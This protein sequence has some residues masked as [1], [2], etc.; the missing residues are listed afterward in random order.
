MV[1]EGEVY[2]HVDSKYV[3]ILVVKEVLPKTVNGR[4]SI[5][6]NTHKK[7]RLERIK[8]TKHWYNDS[9]EILTLQ[10]QF[11]PWKGIL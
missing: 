7:R 9:F 8:I 2:A 3:L 4:A 1:Q 6:P 11:K 10:Y 5:Y